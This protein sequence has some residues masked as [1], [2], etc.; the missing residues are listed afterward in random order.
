[1][2][3]ERLEVTRRVMKAMRHESGRRPL[4][5]R[6]GDGGRQVVIC[7]PTDTVGYAC[8]R[9]KAVGGRATVVVPVRGGLLPLRWHIDMGAPELIAPDGPIHP[10]ST[11][12]MLVDWWLAGEHH[13][14]TFTLTTGSIEVAGDGEQITVPA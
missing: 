13:E 9:V 12:G 5:E 14:V 3:T 11:M 4:V 8:E 6:N 10:G 7:I 2:E 1:M